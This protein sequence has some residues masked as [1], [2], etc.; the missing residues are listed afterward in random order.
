MIRRLMVCGVL[1][2][3]AVSAAAA[4]A[5]AQCGGGCGPWGGMPY[6]N[7]GY[8]SNAINVPTPPYFAL[9]PP[10]YYSH[11]VPR[12]YGYSPF[13]YP[14]SFRTPDVEIAPQPETIINPHL[15]PAPK[16]DTPD[17]KPEAKKSSGKVA[18][19]IIVNP[20]YQPKEGIAAK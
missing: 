14:G 12:T 10:V 19:Q 8:P 13:A 18:A 3:L 15:L 20:F 2:I 9:H 11:A 6:W 1:S 5:S 16:K 7:W 4:S 17:A